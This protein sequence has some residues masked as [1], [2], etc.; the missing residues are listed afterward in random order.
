MAGNSKDSKFIILVSDSDSGSEA[1]DTFEPTDSQPLT[2]DTV[3]SAR[4]KDGNLPVG[5]NLQ[6]TTVMMPTFRDWLGVQEKPWDV[7]SDE[8]VSE[9]NR[10]W[11]NVR[12]QD[13]FKIVASS[14]EYPFVSSLC[15][16]LNVIGVESSNVFF[17]FRQYYY[18]WKR[19]IGLAGLASVANYLTTKFADPQARASYVRRILGENT[20]T[21]PFVYKN[22][23]VSFDFP[24]VIWIY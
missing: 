17:K 2:Q 15:R 6:F 13:N 12:P 22:P 16:D 9:L 8:I 10:I 4:S 23:I 24:I 5:S 11:S 14:D 21:S 1:Q 20:D 18:V 19:D 3:T 7:S